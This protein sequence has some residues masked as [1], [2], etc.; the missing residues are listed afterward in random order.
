[1]DDDVILKIKNIKKYF[2]KKSSLFSS[3]NSGKTKAVDG[4]SLDLYRGETL[5]IVGESGCGKT[6][7]ERIAARLLTP[8][9]GKVF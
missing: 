5:G 9:E 7:L 2:Y 8:D 6:T 3:E 4:V 1:M